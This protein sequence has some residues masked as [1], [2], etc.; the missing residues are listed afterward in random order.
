MNKHL[1]FVSVKRRSE[2]IEDEA[3]TVPLFHRPTA[4][5]MATPQDRPRCEVFVVR[6]SWLDMPM[7]RLS[8]AFTRAAIAALPAVLLVYAVARIIK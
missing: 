8:W 7:L 3:P 6:P 1:R 2:S 4:E 5:A